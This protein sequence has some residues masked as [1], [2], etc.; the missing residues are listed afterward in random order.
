MKTTIGNKKP[1]NKQTILMHNDNKIIDPQEIGHISNVH[2]I[3][4]GFDLQKISS[5][6]LTICLILIAL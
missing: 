4:I 5:L 3:N 2:F 6:M 1:N